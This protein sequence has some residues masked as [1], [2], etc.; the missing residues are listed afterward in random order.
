MSIHRW[1]IVRFGPLFALCLSS[2][3][4]AQ[5]LDWKWP[6]WAESQP[7][8]IVR[9]FGGLTGHSLQGVARNGLDVGVA[10]DKPRGFDRPGVRVEVGRRNWAVPAWIGSTGRELKP[11]DRYLQ[12]RLVIAAVVLSPPAPPGRTHA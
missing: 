12:D 9:A 10:V 4:Q 8:L 2:T 5:P 6:A 3:A 11:A 7:A 1:A